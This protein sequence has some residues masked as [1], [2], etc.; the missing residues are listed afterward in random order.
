M[1]RVKK[2]KKKQ[3]TPHQKNQNKQKQ[4]AQH[5]SLHHIKSYTSKTTYGYSD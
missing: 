4:K 1:E 2:K 3:K 5:H